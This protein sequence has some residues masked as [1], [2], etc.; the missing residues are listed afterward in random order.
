MGKEKST[1]SE[2][3]PSCCAPLK[4]NGKKEKFECEYCKGTY[5]LFELEEYKKSL[6][7]EKKEKEE[8]IEEQETR[9]NDNNKDKKLKN[10]EKKDSKAVNNKLGEKTMSVNTYYCENCG[11]TI[12]LG[13]NTSS[14]SC[15]YCK[16][17]ALIRDRLEEVYQPS[18]IIT[19][20]V[21]KDEAIEKYKSLV[22]KRH[23]IPS[24]FKDSN[25]IQ[26]MEGLY[27][28]FWLYDLSNSVDV[29]ILGT[30]V[31]T[32]SDSQY[33]YTETKY[34]DITG[35]GVLN[36]DNIPND[37]SVRFDDNIMNAIEPFDYNEFKD[38]N[39]S[40]LS[41]YLS[42]KYDVDSEKAYENV[43]K[44][45]TRD[46][47]NYCVENCDGY[48]TSKT[49]KDYSESIN[50]GEIEYVL[51]PVWVLNIKYNDKIYKFSING[52]TGKMVGEIPINW[53]KFLLFLLGIFVFV[54]VLL[55]FIIRGV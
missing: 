3:C 17:T 5:T 48:Y 47:R 55:Y 21:T 37:G 12:V 24:R 35:N 30:K 46:S 1:L 42:E 22:S 15:L 40:Y 32:W 52:Q 10:I 11:A 4:Y 16:S 44:R 34:Y 28:P 41:G 43:S 19:F 26:D 54:F 29:K 50:K 39:I 31:R 7:E 49:I 14:T 33:N 6:K 45:I 20:K 9:D 38:F 13:E 23:F 53:T 25:N 8:Q 18:K 27:V 2:K 51:L 36:F